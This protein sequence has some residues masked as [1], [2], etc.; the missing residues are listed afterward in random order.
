MKRLQSRAELK[1][2]ILLALGHPY[3]NVNLSDEHLDMCIDSSLRHF[4]KY[5]PYGSFEAHYLYTVGAT[6]VTNG[7]IPIP[8][9][10]DAV[11]E[12][13]AKGMSISDLSFAT[14]EYQ[15]S[16]ETFMAAQR[17]NNVSLVDY[18]TLKQR[19]Y[20]TQQII[21]PAKTFEYVRYQRRLIPN[22]T[23][24]EGDIL[25]FH[26]YE[27]VDPE[28]VDIGKPQGSVL[29]AADL[30]DD[31]TLRAIA[32]A[33]AKKTWGM[34]LKKFGSVVLPGGVTLDGQKIYDEGNQEFITITER[35]LDSNPIDFFMG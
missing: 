8:R 23:F 19:L 15:M 18:V 1:Q 29:P 21:T 32:I 2:N 20:H 12:V 22:F 34:I 33:E 16:R 25:A 13:L 10:I 7:Y 30:W 4:F 35:M 24:K 26:V 9:W 3:V 28:A 6:D 5:N 27:N 31:E 11:V 17:F 14:A